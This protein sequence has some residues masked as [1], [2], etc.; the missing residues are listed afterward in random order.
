MGTCVH[1][2]VCLSVCT[3]VKQ[4]KHNLVHVEV[5]LGEG[6]KTVGARWQKR[7]VEI[8]DSYQFE[9]KSYHSMQYHFRS[10]DTWLQGICRRCEPLGVGRDGRV[11]TT[12]SL[13]CSHCPEHAWQSRPSFVPDKR[14][15]FALSD[16]QSGEEAEGACQQEGEGQ[17]ACP[18]VEE[19][20]D[21]S[22]DP[23][24]WEQ[25]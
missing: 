25:G 24:E 16:S 20:Q 3:A 23:G 5:W 11:W 14:S 6:H 17:E 10:I 18:P 8:H 4:Q 13:S 21:H 7:F 12:C 9:S 1:M 22:S 19:E 15:V 2:Y